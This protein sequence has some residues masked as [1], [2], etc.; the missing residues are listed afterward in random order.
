MSAGP[1]LAV[2]KLKEWREN[3][4]TFVREVLKAEPDA[5]QAEVLEAFPKQ[6]RIALQACKGPGKST[7]EAWCGWNFLLTRP[8]PKC[9]ATSNSGDNLRDNLW[10]E[11]SKWQSRSEL[12]KQS[13]TWS[14]DRIYYNRAKETWW[15]SART[16]PK[17]ADA[18]R[19]A[20]T[21]AG[22]H[23]DYVLFLLDE[24][25]SIPDAVMAAAEGAL[26][27]GIE[28]KIMMGGNPTVTSGPLY[29]A[30]TRERALWWRREITGDPDDPKRAPRIDVTWARQ[31][32]EKWGKDHDYV[33]VNVFG[34]F[35]RAQ[36][37]SLIG[38]DDATSAS[39]RNVDAQNVR[40]QA[41][42]LGVD[43][44]RFGDDR[45]VI[46]ARQGS[47]AYKPKTFRGLDLMQLAGQVA[48][49]IEKWAPDAVFV[50]QTGMGGG[51][52]DRLRQ[53][54]HAVIGIDFGSRSIEGKHVNMRT[55]M[56]WKLAEWLKEGGCI[57]DDAELISELT[58]PTYSFNAAQ[59]IALESKDELKRRGLA[60]PDKAD[61][62]ALT[63]AMP[64][65]PRGIQLPGM[66]A[67]NQAATDFDPY[68]EVL[69]SVHGKA[70]TQFDP[71]E[72]RSF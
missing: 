21:L 34:K 57:P 40:G 56:W 64:V 58:A 17:D 60:S 1:E 7:L 39:Q 16:W 31:Q 32:I 3:P 65:A 62:L 18:A 23:A 68:S 52:V 35:P 25:G 28:V 19:Q 41:K 51:V 55:E 54:G 33:R 10:A 59:K 43:V 4:V 36:S 15:M 14:A 61:A 50:D 44:A 29:R 70:Q 53:L 71:F 45:S 24:A 26:S 11:M 22:I 20:D 63:F 42:V 37:N 46:Q 47:C 49:S 67:R 6:N 66:R 2:A 27:T 69:E 72:D 9:V 38:V 12:L 8:Q 30:A 5:W 48:M 13:F